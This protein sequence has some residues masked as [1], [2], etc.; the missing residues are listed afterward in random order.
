MNELEAERIWQR[1]RRQQNQSTKPSEDPVKDWVSFFSPINPKACFI[2]TLGADGAVAFRNG[3]IL[4]TLRPAI[5]VQVVDPT[6]AGDS[7]TAGFLH[8]IWAWK[9]KESDRNQTDDWSPEALG[10]GLLWGCSVGTAAVKIRGASN[11]STPEDISDL[12]AQQKAKDAI[13]YQSSES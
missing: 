1:G 7:F 6:G 8:G 13:V 2:V 10:E 12:L 3:K 9:Q 5:S 4:A 11:P